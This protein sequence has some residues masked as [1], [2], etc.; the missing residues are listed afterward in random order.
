LETRQPAR[1]VDG[2][3]STEF[4][5]TRTGSL[6]I[7]VI[8]SAAKLLAE[9]PEEEKV[10]FQTVVPPTATTTPTHTPTS[11]PE[12]TPTVTSTS[13][14]TPTPTTTPTMTPTP[15]TTPEPISRVSG[16]TLSTVLLQTVALGLV[17]FLIVMLSR[18]GVGDSLRWGLLSMIGALFGYDLYALGIPVGLEATPLVRQWGGVLAAGV[19]CAA[20]LGLYWTAHTIWTAIRDKRS[21]RKNV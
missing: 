19:G 17:V 6:E 5:L 11:T 9:V 12:P 16:G 21:L 2:V 20:V 18:N 7:S 1:T 4:A 14:S 10:E 8:G 3:A 15:T 13:T